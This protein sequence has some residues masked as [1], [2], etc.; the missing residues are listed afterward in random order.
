M[1]ASVSGWRWLLDVWNHVG[2]A[3]Y[4]LA[5]AGAGFAS[6]KLKW[7][8]GLILL[9][10][11]LCALFFEGAFRVHRD[12][13]KDLAEHESRLA[14]G[15]P[16]VEAAL[17]DGRDLYAMKITTHDEWR[18]WLKAAR[19]WEKNTRDVVASELSQS[20]RV[21]FHTGT[22][23]AADVLGSYNEAHSRDRLII[24]HLLKRL[25]EF[26]AEKAA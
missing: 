12:T 4:L 6:F 5:L 17:V 11:L 18:R 20:H 15:C 25:E 13:Y 9:G 21:R 7:W 16:G 26:I 1:T 19:D 3:L 8:I 14:S 22:Y 2:L 10:V 24:S 23:N